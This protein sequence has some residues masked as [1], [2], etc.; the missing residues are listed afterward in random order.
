MR[1]NFLETIIGALVLGV[2][3]LFVIFVYRTV[4]LDGTHGYPVGAVFAKVGGLNVG[5]DV[6][7]NG[8][9]VGTVTDRSL[10]PKTYEAVVTM[11]VEA[12]VR[13]P[14]DTVAV[15]ASEGPLGGKYIQLEPG[16]STEM[17]AEGGVVRET[18]SY[19]S[20]EDQVGEIIFLATSKPA[21]G[22]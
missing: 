15:V 6:R 19:R 5:S 17:I 10:D 21:E 16:K 1:R 11:S 20:L 7:I 12:S 13:L 14:T 18:R 2:A 9:K 8:I 3:V 4:E 22:K